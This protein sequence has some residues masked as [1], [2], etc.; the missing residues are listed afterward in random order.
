M[1]QFLLSESA[2]SFTQLAIEYIVYAAIIVIGIL[3]LFALRRCGRRRIFCRVC[4]PL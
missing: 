1:T 4:K 3:L 2:V